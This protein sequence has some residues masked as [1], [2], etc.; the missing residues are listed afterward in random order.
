M[1]SD[2]LLYFQVIAA[3]FS[4]SASYPLFTDATLFS[5]TASST[6]KLL[7]LLFLSLPPTH[8]LLMLP[9]FLSLPPLPSSYCCYF[10]FLCLLPTIYWCYPFFSHCLLYLQVIAATFSFSASYPLFTDATLFSLTASSTFKLLLLLSFCRLL[11]T[12]H[13]CYLFFSLCLLLLFTA[14]TKVMCHSTSLWLAHFILVPFSLSSHYF[15]L[16]NGGRG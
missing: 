8:Y 15:F 7:L 10:F 1:I 9:F 4:F 2:C 14:I 11:P 12:I 3:T 6:F 13:W 16:T 5:L